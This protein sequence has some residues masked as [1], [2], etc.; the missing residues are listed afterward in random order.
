MQEQ[1][2]PPS[3]E[4][5]EKIKQY[6]KNMEARCDEILPYLRKEVEVQKL[7]YEIDNYHLNRF[8]VKQKLAEINTPV[9][10]TPKPKPTK[11][12]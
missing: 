9:D 10:K 5:I 4:E 8:L 1:N 11:K 7:Y 12:K 6:Q 2:N 3:P